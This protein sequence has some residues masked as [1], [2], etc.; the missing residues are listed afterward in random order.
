MLEHLEDTGIPK[1]LFT[2]T[3]YVRNSLIL[4]ILKTQ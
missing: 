3:G 4:I 2:F 1:M